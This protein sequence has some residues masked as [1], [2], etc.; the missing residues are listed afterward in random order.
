MNLILV[1]VLIKEPVLI[2]HNENY[3]ILEKKFIKKNKSK[4]IILD[5]SDSDS[6]SDKSTN[7][8]REV[9]S[10]SENSDD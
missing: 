6:D 8:H 7:S 9:L 10:S 4:K 1:A 3:T 2:S 5:E